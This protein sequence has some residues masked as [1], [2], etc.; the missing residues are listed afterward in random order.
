MMAITTV[1]I[2]TIIIMIIII[3]III[4]FLFN[5][6]YIITYTEKLT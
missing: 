3:I 2:I 1:I 5:L 4:K 6:G